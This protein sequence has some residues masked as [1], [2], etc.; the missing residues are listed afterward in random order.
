MVSDLD[1]VYALPDGL[2]ETTALVAQ[3]DGEG[4]FGVVSGQG[5]CVAKGSA[6]A[7]HRLFTQRHSG[8]M[9]SSR[10]ADTGTT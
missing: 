1:V 5:V 3:N 9:S 7:L 8:N 4:A 10:V 2:D 6:W